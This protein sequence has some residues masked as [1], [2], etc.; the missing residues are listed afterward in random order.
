[1]LFKFIFESLRGIL[2]HTFIFFQCLV[3]FHM[4]PLTLTETIYFTW[5]GHQILYGFVCCSHQF[6]VE[7]KNLSVV[8]SLLFKAYEVFEKI[9]SLIL[10]GVLF[11]SNQKFLSFY[12]N[13]LFSSKS[14][15]HHRVQEV[16][17]LEKLLILCSQLLTLFD[18]G[19]LD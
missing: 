6:N 11:Q 2:K 18:I 3:V 8:Y 12:V 9:N 14:L 15:Q 16:I 13:F 10:G 17:K 19:S 5:R 4:H 7:L 1:M